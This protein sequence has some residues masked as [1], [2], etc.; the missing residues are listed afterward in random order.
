MNLSLSASD[1]HLILGPPG[2]GKTHVIKEMITEMLKNGQKVLATAYTNRAVDNVL[3][4]LGD[5]DEETV[6]RI[7]S[8]TEISPESRRYSLD[9]RM[10]NIRTG[11]KLTI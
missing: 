10:K 5:V 6:L 8:Y 11:A 4:K 1:F 3:E 9:E 2:T 7:G